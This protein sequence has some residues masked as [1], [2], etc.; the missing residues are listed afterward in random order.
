MPG[1][2]VKAILDRFD[3]CE[4]N[5]REDHKQIFD[6][7]R[8]LAVAQASSISTDKCAAC[9]T[10]LN[11]KIQ[12]ERGWPPAF[13]YLLTALVGIMAVLGTLL[14]VFIS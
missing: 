5:N 1:D 11:Q 14:A 4:E 10:V 12:D 3:K 8:E 6:L 2:D 9:Q 13:T 7:L